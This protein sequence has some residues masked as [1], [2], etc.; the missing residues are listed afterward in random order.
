MKIDICT[1]KSRKDKIWNYEEIDLSTFIKRISTTT[2]TSEI[3]KE[4][5]NLPKSAK[6]N[7]KDVGGFVLGKLKD[8]IHDEVV[9][10]VEKGKTTV[11]DICEIMTSLPDYGEGLPLKAEGYVCDFYKK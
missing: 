1:G 2:R 8:N 4:Y 9:L 6:D 3:L 5:K 7:I 10:E 11:E